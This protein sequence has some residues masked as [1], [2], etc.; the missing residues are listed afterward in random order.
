MEY[1]H[2]Y[3]LVR[4]I[5]GTETYQ[6]LETLYQKIAQDEAARSM[7]RDLRALEVG[8]ELKQLSGEALTREE[9]EHYERM[10]ETVRLNPDIDRLLKLE[11]GLAQMYDDIQNSSRTV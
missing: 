6:E 9:T 5:E 11:Q 1:H 7:L 2:A 8:L 4:A 3:D 10:M